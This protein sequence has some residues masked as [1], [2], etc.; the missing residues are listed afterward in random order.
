MT[1]YQLAGVVGLILI[2]LIVISTVIWIR[3]SDGRAQKKACKER[4]KRYREYH[5]Q[6]AMREQQ[7]LF[8]AYV[9]TLTRS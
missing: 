5:R 1:E 3:I 7:Q 4:A 9:D 2:V 6:E 8:M